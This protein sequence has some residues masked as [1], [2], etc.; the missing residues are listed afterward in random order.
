MCSEECKHKHRNEKQLA[1]YHEVLSD[2]EKAK[3]QAKREQTMA[4]NE[5]HLWPKRICEYCGEEFW[6]TKSHQKY[7]CDECG[8]KGYEMTDKGRDPHEKEGHRF[9]KRIC[10]ICGQEF[11]PNGPN[12]V[13]CSPGCSKA[14]Y[15]KNA[16]ERYEA[17]K[18]VAAVDRTA[19]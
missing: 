18:A 15:K 7:C 10:A 16:R 3:R 2:K 13:C 11:W 5:G 6:P 14:F 19:V 1:Y 8:R 9:Y 4:E 17:R 12:T